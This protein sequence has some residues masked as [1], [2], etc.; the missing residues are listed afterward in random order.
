MNKMKTKFFVIALAVLTIGLLGSCKKEDPT[1]SVMGVTLDKTTMTLTE[2][3]NAQLVATVKP[4]NATDK[5]VSWKSDKT[6]VTTV[7]QNGN[8]HAVAPGTATITVTTTDGS[9]TATCAVTVDAKVYPVESVS[10]D[11]TTLT[12]TEGDNAQLVATV[13][14]DNATDKT[15]S[16]TSN[17]PVVAAVNS[18]GNVV[19]ATPGEAIIYVI[20]VDGAKT[21]TC[22]VTVLENIDGALLGLFSVSA[23]KKVRFSKGN[24][25]AIFV[26]H[27]GISYSFRFAENQYDYIGNAPGNTTIESMDRAVVDLFGWSTDAANNNFG[28]NTSTDVADY[29]GN[30]RDWGNKIG[31]GNTWRTLSKDEWK[32]LFITRTVNG[33]TGKD[34]SYSLDI[35]YGGIMGLV[36]YPDDYT[37]SVLSG[38]VDSL[39]EGV[40]FLPAAGSRFGSDVNN[41]GDIGYYWSSTALGSLLAYFVGFDSG[42]VDP[43]CIDNRYGGSSGYSVRLITESK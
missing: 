25:Q 20:T 6:D 39:P 21:A 3:D 24:L 5:S 23:T 7:D 11:K 33:G 37:G 12:L 14:P 36:L 19:A 31:D 41:V 32:Y 35:T 27:G 42:F 30:F 13:K 10:L 38:T 34:K 9:K 17:N 22:K 43:G 8:V 2:G 18:K 16:W 26:G 28:I 15:V 29:S 4:D 40:V 1:V